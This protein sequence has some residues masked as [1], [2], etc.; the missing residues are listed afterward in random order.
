MKTS[1]LLV[2]MILMLSACKKSGNQSETERAEADSMCT[3]LGLTPEF[4]GNPYDSAGYWHNE[5]LRYM[6]RY[7]TGQEQLSAE[8]IVN[9]LIQNPAY[10][11]S[12]RMKT[13]MLALLN[14]LEA[15]KEAFYDQAVEAISASEEAKQYLMGIAG[16]IR[17]YFGKNYQVMKDSITVL[18]QQVLNRMELPHAERVLILMAASI[19]RYSAYYW[20]IEEPIDLSGLKLKEVLKVIATATADPAGFISRWFGGGSGFKESVAHGAACSEYQRKM[21]DYIPNG[22]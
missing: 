1:F 20:S 5:M 7:K 8:Q 11:L 22:N 4:E 21:I 2:M 18:E 13:R 14:Q 12:E 19:G 15:A 6:R 3:T 16:F 17:Q 10:E 9:L